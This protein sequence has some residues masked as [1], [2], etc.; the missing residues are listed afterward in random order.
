MT[1]LTT[2][3]SPEVM[4][5][6]EKSHGEKQ[7]QTDLPVAAQTL[8]LSTTASTETRVEAVLDENLILSEKVDQGRTG[9]Q[10][11]INGPKG[12][13]PTRYGDW[14]SKGRCHDF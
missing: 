6:N 10:K 8:H 2:E 11:E 7:S 14:E 13:E 5:A 9:L 3:Q 1:T 12:L 4:S